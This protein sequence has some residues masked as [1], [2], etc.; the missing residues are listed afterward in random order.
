MGF[1]HY[2]L[3]FESVFK[4]SVIDD[5]ADSYLK[6][7]TPI[8]CVR[9]NQR[10][11][12]RDLM[13]IAK[14]LDAKAL[15][16]GHYVRQKFNT[17]SVTLHKAIDLK[18]DQSYFLFATTRDQLDFLRFPLG[19]FSK[20]VTRQHARRFGLDISEKPDSQDICF[21]PSTPGGYKDVVAKLRPGA[22]DPGKII[23]IDGRVLGEHQGIIHFTVGQRKGLKIAFEEPLFVISL[24]AAK[25]EVVV[26]PREALSVSHIFLKE[27]N[28]LD[29]KL[30]FESGRLVEVKFRSQQSP[31]AAYVFYSGE[32]QA[33]IDLLTPEY[34]IASGQAC[35]L[36]EDTQVLGGGW[37]TSTANHLT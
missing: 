30:I 31:I 29:S 1:P 25:K 34:G 27:M 18:R 9:C 11:K 20:D 15:I 5:F 14:D 35:V 28:W 8:P 26:G 22:L 17:D 6:G 12:F 7:E 24:N 3:D 36:Y 10:V 37:I 16:T 13:N 21:V 19:N 23:H 32:T 2:V 4:A 33:R